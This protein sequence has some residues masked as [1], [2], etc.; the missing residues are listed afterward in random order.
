M[1]DNIETFE[2]TDI[3]LSIEDIKI[4]LDNSYR[5]I[6]DGI[7]VINT[8]NNMSKI[9][10]LSLETNILNNDLVKITLNTLNLGLESIGCNELII[11]EN[12]SLEDNVKD[13]NISIEGIG[14]DI[15]LAIKKIFEKIGNLMNAFYENIRK[16]FG[17]AK[18]KATETKSKLDELPDLN[19]FE[20]EKGAQA[21]FIDKVKKMLPLYSVMG[22]DILSDSDFQKYNECI[23][24]GNRWILENTTLLI[25]G[26]NNDTPNSLSTP[27]KLKLIDTHSAKA[28]QNVRGI[29]EKKYTEKVNCH[30]LVAVKH[31]GAVL[32]TILKD[33]SVTKL[34][35][36]PLTIDNKNLDNLHRKSL[37]KLNKNRIHGILEMI[38]K[39]GEEEEKFKKDS[40][41][42]KQKLELEFKDLANKQLGSEAIFT[43]NTNTA[44]NIMSSVAEALVK[45][46]A[47]YQT[48]SDNLTNIYAVEAKKV[49]K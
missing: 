26:T 23:L 27:S 35:H 39:L 34:V 29:I 31:N 20:I 33:K 3:L 24:I 49:N 6:N 32:I 41:S 38:N 17:I 8:L 47:V 25:K 4:E 11:N 44:G 15:W 1:Y 13:I 22:L 5:V 14:A 37:S 42:F 30:Y 18:V 45:H 2:Y 19:D 21:K 16:F 46:I 48:I 9:N 36:S 7:R 12:I 10:S 43:T 40:D 28:F